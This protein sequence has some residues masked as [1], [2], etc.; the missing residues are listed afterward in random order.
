MAAFPPP[1]GWKLMAIA[2]PIASGIIMPFARGGSARGIV[3]AYTPPFTLPFRPSAWSI[4]AVSSSIASCA[5]GATTP[6][7]ATP[8]GEPNGVRLN[9]SASCSVVAS[10]AGSPRPMTCMYIVRGVL[11]RR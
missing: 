2:E 6:V 11:R 8:T 9:A 4:A 10:L 3:I 1:V 7:V 5:G